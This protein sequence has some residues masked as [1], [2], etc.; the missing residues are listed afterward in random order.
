MLKARR[1]IGVVIV[2]GV[3]V[4]AAGSSAQSVGITDPT[5]VVMVVNRDSNELAFLDIATRK[6]VGK[7]FLGNNAN[8]HMATMSPD[9][10]YAVTGG[11]RSNKAYIVDLRTL[12]LVKAIPIGIGPEHQAISPDGRF[13]Y[14]GNPSSD[15]LSVIDMNSLTEVRRI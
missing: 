9:G 7:V 3:A 5:K 10:R 11:T 2:A 8:P 6:M 4:A 13:Y 15:S 14:Q 1:V 12:R